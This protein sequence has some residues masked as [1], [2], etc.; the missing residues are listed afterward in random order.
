M[1]AIPQ[2]HVQTTTSNPGIASFHP[3]MQQLQSHDTS[4]EVH[5]D[6]VCNADKNN[7]PEEESK[8]S[9]ELSK[10]SHDVKPVIETIDK[11]MISSNLI[12]AC[13][14]RQA[15]ASEWILQIA[16]ADGTPSSQTILESD[17]CQMSTAPETGLDPQNGMSLAYQDDDSANPHGTEDGIYDASDSDS[18][19]RD[20]MERDAW[21]QEAQE[22]SAAVAAAAIKAVMERV[23][24][25][26]YEKFEAA[27]HLLELQIKDQQA[28]AAE[29]MLVYVRKRLAALKIAHAWLGWRGSAARTKRINSII[30]MQ[31]CA[32]SFLARK[33]V[34]SLKEAEALRKIVRFHV[35]KVWFTLASAVRNP[36]K[37]LLTPAS[38]IASD[39]SL[40]CTALTM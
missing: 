37:S 39:G 26:E 16:P 36:G 2:N 30:L 40:C 18:C 25:A 15:M 27:Q 21:V 12:A 17:N 34:A 22:A 9:S 23:A 38:S 11:N 5:H 8:T 32:R 28:R 10:E 33:Q 4:I 7:S 14:R 31:A 13:K 1:E 3:T 24:A 6:S 19:Q 35:S 20:A 29:K